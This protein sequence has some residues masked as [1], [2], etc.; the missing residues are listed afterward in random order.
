MKKKILSLLISALLAAALPVTAYA[1]PDWPADTGVQSEAG[2]VMDMDSETVLFGQN[3]HAQKAPAS[4]TK[5]LTALVVV[6]NSNL[7]DM[8]TY[9]HDAVYNVESGSGNKN[10]IEEGDQMTVRDALHHMLL[11]SSNQSANALAEHVGG[12]RD[13]FVAMMNEKAAELGCTE[14]HFANPSGLNDETQLTT[15]YDMAL[16]GKAAYENETLLEIASAK[17][18]RLPATAN[19]PEG[20]TVYMEHQ[21]MKEDSEF[22]YPYTVTGKTGYTSIAGQTLITYAE[23]DDREQISV[24]MKSMEF[25]HYSDTISLMDFGFRRFQNINISE[26]ETGY[27]SG[28]QPVELGGRSYEPS[29]LSIDTSAVITIPQDAVFTDAEKKVVTELPD[30]HPDGAAALLT[31]TYNDRKVGECYIISA[32]KAAEDV[33]AK[34]AAAAAPAGEVPDAESSE[35]AENQETADGSGKGQDEAAGAQQGQQ[36][37]GGAGA[38]AGI[39]GNTALIGVLVFLAA[40]AAGT[41]VW[42]IKK[43]QAEERRRMEERKQRRR[44]RLEEMGCTQEEFERLR[45]EWSI[46]QRT[47]ENDRQMT[48]EVPQPVEEDAENAPEGASE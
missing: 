22:Y 25:T 9:S 6:E 39:S 38:S 18:Y 15:V 28:S 31:Y 11:T 45:A 44:Q 2:I 37:S 16:I 12:S 42:Y 8:I 19:N 34:A 20:V 5:V 24:T 23:K 1:K 4:I 36:T 26:N 3:L 43:Q 32:S 17:S 35:A 46:R 29:D 30:D 48:E 10:A 40:A 13:G 14:S 7:D 47:E 33:E 41:A 21:M 27:T